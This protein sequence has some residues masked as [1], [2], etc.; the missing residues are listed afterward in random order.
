MLI[1]L[2]F[3]CRFG[4]TG[5]RS[6]GDC[7]FE[8]IIESTLVSLISIGTLIG[9]LSNSITSD[10]LGR[11]RSLAVGV[12]FFILGNIVQITAMQS[13]V[14][15]MLG[16]FIAGLGVGN[17][18]VGVPM[19]Q[20]ET[21]PKEIRGAV[22]ASYQLMITIGILVSN[23]VNY[24]VYNIQESDASWR[25]VIGLGIAF[26]IPL[27]VGLFLVPES[28]R[29]L[30]GRE[31]WG[32]ARGA[33]ARLRGV[34]GD[35]GGKVVEDDYRD[36]YAVLERERRAGK[37]FVGRVFCPEEEWDSQ[38]CLSDFS[39]CVYPLSAVSPLSPDA[40]SLMLNRQW[41]GV[42][43]FFYYGATIF[44]SAGIDNPIRTQLILGAINVG[45]TF[46]GLHI[47][48]K[49]GRRRPLFIGAIW[50]A[51][52]LCVFATVGTVMNPEESRTAGIVLIVAAAMFIASFAGTWGPM[53][54]V[55]IGELFPLRTRARQASLATAGNWL[56]NCAFFL[57][58]LFLGQDD[59]NE[60]CSHD[61]VP[62]APGH[63]GYILRVRIRLCGV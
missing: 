37:G 9:A 55:V 6:S 18:S 38:A 34:K 31:R 22:V 12:V 40:Q 14:H 60:K 19:F 36:M 59:A 53:A 32:E 16:R 20:S 45:M 33:M 39:G 48:E 25:I 58:F 29:W 43:Y 46:Y 13:W 1:F 10:W 61:I 52:W 4:Q 63:K 15:M 28:P 56:G 50:Q 24:G 23:C 8:P 51:L 11:R 42:N 27:G 54:W 5:T 17:L 30:A 44:E 49:Y 57:Y 21:A 26:L 35:E 62:H 3:K 41:T 7:A 2:D 47:V